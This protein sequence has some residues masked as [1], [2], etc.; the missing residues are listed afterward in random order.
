MT[1]ASIL[2]IVLTVP[3]HARPAA[4]RVRARV[5]AGNLIR[6][7]DGRIA[8]L[9]YGLMT[10][11]DDVQ[12]VAL[13]RFIAHMCTEEWEGAALDL[14]LLG[15]WVCVCGGGGVE[16]SGGTQALLA[17]CP[18]ACRFTLYCLDPAP[19]GHASVSWLAAT[20]TCMHACMHRA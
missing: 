1:P 13:V 12:R 19:G 9:D 7:P 6:T 11:M 4:V 3:R 8:I 14:Q 5:P 15:E 16:W 18:P 17:R 2:P 10:Q 20:P